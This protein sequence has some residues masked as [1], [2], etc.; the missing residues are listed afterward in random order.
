MPAYRDDWEERLLADPELLLRMSEAIDGPFHILY[1]ARVAENIEGFRSVFTRK[2]VDGVIY[3]GKKANKSASVVQACASTGV[4]VDVSS[5]GEF[6]ATLHEG[7][8]GEHIVVTGPA[9]S[10]ALLTLAARHRALIAI[11][12]LAELSRL[13]AIGIPARVLLRVLPTGSNSRFGMTREELNEALDRIDAE[14][15]R[16]EGFSFHL[17]GYRIEPRAELAADLIGWCGRAR[18]LGLP[19]NTI[20]IGGGFGVDYVPAEAWKTFLGG[21]NPRWFH[22]DQAPTTDYYPYHFPHA[23]PAML[24]AVLEHQGLADSLRTNNIRLVIE[25]GRALLDQAG[26]TVFQVQG[27]KTRQAHG[28]PY[29][30]LTVNG[31]SFSLSE[32]WFDSEFLPDPALWPNLPGDLTPTCVGSSSCLDD[33]MLSR[34]RIPLPRAAL[35]GDLLVYPNTAGY[36]MDSNES[37]FHQLPLPPKVIAVRSD[38]GRYR[39]AIDG[40]Y[41]EWSLDSPSPPN[42]RMTYQRISAIVKRLGISRY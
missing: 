31:T 16:L 40:R 15:I 17:S 29:R 19:A 3:Y 35:L 39:F 8:R 18:A 14:L 2:G 11:D 23:G 20:S 34:R 32:Q 33:D 1:P 6:D 12:E 26:C 37:S 21:V 5:V 4:G 10:E 7:I 9:K 22:G 38:D 24:A 25:P 41:F 13:T 36:Q 42:T 27:A 28:L 30:L